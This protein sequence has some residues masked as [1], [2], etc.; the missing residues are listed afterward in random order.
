MAV[1]LLVLVV[2][3]VVIVVV[4]V[5]RGH[6]CGRRFGCC[7]GC[8]C[9]CGRGRGRGRGGRR[10]QHPDSPFPPR[11]PLLKTPFALESSSARLIHRRKI[12]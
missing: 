12:A 9:C 2:L 4:V 8:G 6:R 1:V 11:N 7:R 10:P 5:C 3:A